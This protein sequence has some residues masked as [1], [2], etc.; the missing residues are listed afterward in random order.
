M[1]AERERV[2]DRLRADRL[3]AEAAQYRTAE[4]AFQRIFDGERRPARIKVR[5]AFLLRPRQGSPL[6]PAMRLLT[7]NGTALGFYLS[8]LLEIQSR[9]PPRRN[10]VIANT[11]PLDTDGVNLGWK[12]LLPHAPDARATNRQLQR[13]LDRLQGARL[14][15]LGPPQTRDR[16][17]AFRLLSETGT[18]RRTRYSVPVAG[19]D[20]VFRLPK[21]FYLRGWVHVL[22]AAEIILLM[23]LLDLREQFGSGGVYLADTRKGEYCLT[24]EVYERHTALTAYGLIDRLDDPDRRGDGTIV[25][26][27]DYGDPPRPWRFLVHP[28]R[29]QRDAHKTVFDALHARSQPAT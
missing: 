3:V 10:T 13:T 18:L 22:T 19:G 1:T 27:S 8:A 20:P 12:E 9:R 23:V 28:D 26:W 21:D 2:R 25:R 14:V 6:S 29:L 16:Y 5:R 4:K 11:R 7:R 24:K 15:Q 17:A